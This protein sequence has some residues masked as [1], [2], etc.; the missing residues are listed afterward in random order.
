M[1]PWPIM[2]ALL[3]LLS[4]SDDPICKGTP[5]ASFRVMSSGRPI[6]VRNFTFNMLPAVGTT[7]SLVASS[8]TLSDMSLGSMPTVLMRYGVRLGTNA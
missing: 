4:N 8:S 3:P 7:S 6:L 2:P 5:S 1:P